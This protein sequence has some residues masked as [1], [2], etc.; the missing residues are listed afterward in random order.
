VPAPAPADP[1][2]PTPVRPGPPSPETVITPSMTPFVTAGMLLL[3]L[4]VVSGRAL[5][6]P[7][8]TPVIVGVFGVVVAV[9]LARYVGARHTDEPWI[10]SF[11]VWGMV[12]KL[13]GTIARY[14]VFTGG[15][16]S[17][18]SDAE[19]YGEY[20][21]EYLQGIAEPLNDLRKTNFV[22]VVTARVYLLV[23]DDLVA[24]FLVFGVFAFI[25]AY[26]WYRA[27]AEGVP[28][29]NRKLYAAFMFFAPSL[30]FWPS[31]V[32]KEALMLLGLGL[33]AMGTVK[34]LNGQLLRGFL[35]A[36]PGGWLMWV[37]RPHLLAFAT[38]AAAAALLVGRGRRS[39]TLRGSLA[40]PLG[41]VALVF[42]GVFAMNQAAEFLGMEDVSLTSV[43][44]ELSDLN[45]STS[46]GGSAIE[47]E[48]D[49]TVSLTPLSVPQGA[50]TVLLRPFPWEVENASQ[51]LACLESAAF[52]WFLVTRFGSVV[53][54]IRQFRAAPYLF[55]CWVMLAFY[56]V[57]FSSFGNMGLLV[58][59]RS[60]IL[61]A[62]F[63]LLCVEQLQERQ[64]QEPDGAAGSRPRVSG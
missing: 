34:V 33:A 61:P 60:L 40:R 11:I 18:R 45:E 16:E 10:G 12:T 29:L 50:V 27:G 51:I 38:V 37:V 2:D 7:A 28:S 32:G 59:Q 30:V 35:I 41:L 19:E 47:R 31:S 25:G 62:F 17:K 20:G 15:G 5:E 53:A 48:E 58:R 26:L 63:V 36:A 22:R 13:A 64:Q 56:A 6:T 24:A 44:Q 4:T 49:T 52:A 57:A 55:F 3:G 8:I 1:G 46:Q 54:S 23:G 42:I 14:Y 21:T 43:E 9:G 39:Q